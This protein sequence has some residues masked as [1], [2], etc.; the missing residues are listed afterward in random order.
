VDRNI[1]KVRE[2]DRSVEEGGKKGRKKA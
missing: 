1:G 2:E